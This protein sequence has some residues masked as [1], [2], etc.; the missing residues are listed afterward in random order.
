MSLKDCVL[1]LGGVAQVKSGSTTDDS[2]VVTSDQSV[3]LANEEADSPAADQTTEAADNMEFE[4][5][6]KP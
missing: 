4:V 5:R 3:S 2:Y 6:I 1:I